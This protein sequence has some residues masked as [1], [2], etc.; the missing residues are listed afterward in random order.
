MVRKN[1]LFGVVS[2]IFAGLRESGI[3]EKWIETY[4]TK[5]QSFLSA[6]EVWMAGEVADTEGSSVSLQFVRVLSL[7]LVT[8]VGIEVVLFCGEIYLPRKLGKWWGY[9]RI[10]V[11]GWLRDRRKVMLDKVEANLNFNTI[12]VN[13]D[14]NCKNEIYK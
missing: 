11:V 12:N 6:K 7:F 8:L 4:V 3:Y 14:P 1:Y 9:Q 10:K 2:R 5:F 13:S